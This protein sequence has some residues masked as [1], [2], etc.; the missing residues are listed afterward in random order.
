M[1]ALACISVED[2]LVC[3]VLKDDVVREVRQNVSNYLE[4]NHPTLLFYQIEPSK[5]G[6]SLILPSSIASNSS[7]PN[8]K[9]I[10][11]IL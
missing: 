2:A 1:G 7:A 3:Q 11:E 10:F 9:R 6:A 8:A 4:K 5:N